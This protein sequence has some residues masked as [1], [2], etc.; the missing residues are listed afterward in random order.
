M[1]LEKINQDNK[2]E[3]TQSFILKTIEG[4]QLGI[5]SEYSK[6]FDLLEKSRPWEKPTEKE[7]QDATAGTFK[8]GSREIHWKKLKDQLVVVTKGTSTKEHK[9]YSVINEVLRNLE[10]AKSPKLRLEKPIGF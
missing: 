5:L 7:I 9:H 10:V 3:G 4:G 6:L 1:G 2:P 8:E